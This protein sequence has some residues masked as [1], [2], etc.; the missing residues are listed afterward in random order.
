MTPDSPAATGSS[1]TDTALLLA[2]IMQMTEDFADADK[3]Y[4]G[5]ALDAAVRVHHG[6]ILDE[7]PGPFSNLRLDR[8]LRN[9]LCLLRWGVGDM[10]VLLCSVLHDTLDEA[11]NET[12]RIW[13]TRRDSPPETPER[14]DAWDKAATIQDWLEFDFGSRI[15]SLLEMVSYSLEHS[16]RGS[17]TGRALK[18]ARHA[19]AQLGQDPRYLLLETPNL[20]DRVTCLF[21]RYGIIAH[22][23]AAELGAAYLPAVE[24]FRL[25]AWD[26]P[27]IADLSEVWSKGPRV[28][29]PGSR[30][31]RL[32]CA[33]DEARDTLKRLLD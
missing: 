27:E 7:P 26:T 30:M 4:L 29:L 20:V 14:S 28:L 24:A 2:G 16:R 10:G 8:I 9:T 15:Y 6:Q 22:P 25:A 19:A 33:L 13:D 23:G 17:Q 11:L 18:Y 5:Y 1:R 31:P 32:R 3:E 21:G 12:V